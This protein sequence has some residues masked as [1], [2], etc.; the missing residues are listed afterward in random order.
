MMDPPDVVPS[1]DLLVTL[2]AGAEQAHLYSEMSEVLRR[3]ESSIGDLQAWWLMTAFDYVLTQPL[4]DAA[5]RPRRGA[6]TE[7]LSNNGVCYPMPLAMVPNEVKALWSA[8]AEATNSPLCLARLHHLLFEMHEGN[9]GRHAKV[10]AAAYFTLGT[11]E[12]D[13]LHRVAFLYW[14]RELSRKIK[15]HD[16]AKQVIEPLL[17]IAQDSLA[18]ATPEPGVALPALQ[19]VADED[20][21]NPTLQDLLCQAREAYNQPWLVAQVIAIQEVVA[22]GDSDSKRELRRELVQQAYDFAAGHKGMLRM[23]YMEDAARMA[24]DKE[25]PDLLDQ[26]TSA[27]QAMTLDDLEL[28]KH[29]F[30][31]PFPKEAADAY[32]ASLVGSASLLDAFT[33]LIGNDPP[34]GNKDNNAALAEHLKSVAVF[35]SLI[36]KVHLGGDGLPQVKA[37]TDEDREDERLAEVEEGHLIIGAEVTA[38]IL[39]A[40][41]EQFHSTAKELSQILQSRPHTTSHTAQTLSKALHAFESNQFEE[42]AAL[43]M[44]KIEALVR[45]RLSMTGDLPYRIQRQQ[46]PGQYPTLNTL[47]ATIGPSLDPS[48][49]RFLRT[50]LVSRFGRNYR[51]ELLHGFVAEVTRT[52]AA[53]VLLAALYLALAQHDEAAIKDTDA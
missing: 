36:P 26:A 49:H 2:R 52:N 12:L 43:A 6:F 45:A 38:Q 5:G 24:R 7:T 8:T 25:C 35:S 16:D 21:S 3:R 1:E 13:R 11:G 32:I 10:A 31:V 19:I 41:L 37:V 51:N 39:T 40:L 47:L 30:S 29:P 42:A 28:Q 9:G 20:P 27:M 48:W 17:R 34:T 33:A 18:Q 14:A 23:V 15:A 44:P 4:G 22:Q 53:L 46:T 50:F